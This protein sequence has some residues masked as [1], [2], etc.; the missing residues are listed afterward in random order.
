M[1][2]PDADERAGPGLLGRATDRGAWAGARAAQSSRRTLANCW[3]NRGLRL[4][5]RS[6]PAPCPRRGSRARLLVGARRSGV[7]VAL[8]RSA[9]RCGHL[10]MVVGEGECATCSA[11][12][13]GPLHR[14][15]SPRRASFVSG[16]AVG[17]D[18]RPGPMPSNEPHRRAAQG[19]GARSPDTSSSAS[20]PR[21]QHE[22]SVDPPGAASG[23]ECAVRHRRSGDR[24]CRSVVRCRLVCPR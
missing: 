17:A 13:H 5:C 18:A 24:R 8:V 21:L 3:R 7:Q 4:A 15:P 12:V 2:G 1:Q 20:R 6:T 23:S 11:G 9:A 19:W 14:A 22:V 10:A 16:G